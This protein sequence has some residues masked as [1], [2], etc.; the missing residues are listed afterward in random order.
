MSG[1]AVKAF[2]IGNENNVADG[3]TRYG[4]GVVTVTD[5]ALNQI[6]GKPCG[7]FEARR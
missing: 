5:F 2:A 1:K 4:T 7:K 6:S 3:G